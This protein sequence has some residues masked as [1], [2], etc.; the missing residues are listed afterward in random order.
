MQESKMVT[1]RNF[2]KSLAAGLASV[3]AVLI[4]PKS[5]EAE[6]EVKSEQIPESEGEYGWTQ[7]IG[8]DNV[9]TS[10][11][12]WSYRY[13]VCSCGCPYC[14]FWNDESEDIYSL[15]NGEQSK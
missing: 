4:A 3:G 6:P 5:V 9:D 1:R 2:F 11:T 8:A 12:V 14:D 7:T 15:E 13:P 10:Y